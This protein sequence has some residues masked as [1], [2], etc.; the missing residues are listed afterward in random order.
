M[1]EDVSCEEFDRFLQGR[2][3][4]IRTSKETGSKLGCTTSKAM[5][6]KCVP[7]PTSSLKNQAM[8]DVRPHTMQEVV[9]DREV[10]TD[11]GKAPP[12]KFPPTVRDGEVQVPI[13]V[14]TQ[15]KQPPLVKHDAGV[16]EAASGYSDVDQKR[17]HLGKYG[18]PARRQPRQIIWTWQ[19][20]SG[21]AIYDVLSMNGGVM[22]LDRRVQALPDTSK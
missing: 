13:K 18:L 3:N 9:E 8:K 20:E 12:T 1:T 14:P 19:G 15:R 6:K 2:T 16:W 11:I 10:P 22:E 21:K 7:S 4:I 5:G 17:T